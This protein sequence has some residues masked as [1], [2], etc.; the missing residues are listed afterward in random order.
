[1]VV[2]DLTDGEDR[3]ESVGSTQSCHRRASGSETGSDASLP[4]R[5]PT[6]WCTRSVRWLSK[7]TLWV[8]TMF[9]P[10]RTANRSRPRRIER[11]GE[12]RPRRASLPHRAESRA[13]TACGWVRPGPAGRRPARDVT[14][15]AQECEVARHRS[16]PLPNPMPGSTHACAL[17]AGDSP[18]SRATSSS[19]TSCHDTGRVGPRTPPPANA[20]QVARDV[21][22]P[23]LAH[24]RAPSS[25]S[26]AHPRRH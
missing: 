26:N 10:A 21:G 4:R 18:A 24:G 14:G 13:G 16:A 9:A 19:A 7:A 20:T 15:V 5:G 8:R 23:E 6:F 1:M 22:G 25:G 3:R 12:I 11:L 2:N 17:A